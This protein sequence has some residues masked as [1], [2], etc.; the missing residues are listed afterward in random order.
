[1]FSK[2]LLLFFGGGFSPISIK[3]KEWREVMAEGE[4][5]RDR[6]REREGV[7]RPQGEPSKT[8][9][10]YYYGEKPIWVPGDRKCV[11][12][13]SMLSHYNKDDR[14]FSHSKGQAF[15]AE[16]NGSHFSSGGN[17]V[18]PG[19]RHTGSRSE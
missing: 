14:C 7:A 13:G 15:F 12:C 11:L 18:K 6:K 1:V 10:S 17:A 5:K 9:S 2:N 8:Q 3:K 4:E 16:S 19:I